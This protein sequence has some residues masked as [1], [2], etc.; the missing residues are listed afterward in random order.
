[1]KFSDNK[2]SDIA[3]DSLTKTLSSPETNRWILIIVGDLS[4]LKIYH[5][6]RLIIAIELSMSSS[7]TYLCQRLIFVRDLSLSETSLSNLLL[8]GN[9]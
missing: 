9:I 1:M 5:H 3:R 2:N 7:E 6:Q 8:L 4:S